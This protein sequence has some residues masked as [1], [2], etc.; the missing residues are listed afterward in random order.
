MSLTYRKFFTLNLLLKKFIYSINEE[1]IIF[2]IHESLDDDENDF[3]SLDPK[4]QREKVLNIYEKVINFLTT[5]GANIAHISPEFLL[6]YY[7]YKVS[8]KKID[9]QKKTFQ[10]C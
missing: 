6:N 9:F 8:F 4:E 2:L 5:Q 10:C 7:H 3:E 1:L